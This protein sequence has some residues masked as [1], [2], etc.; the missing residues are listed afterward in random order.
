MIG[1]FGWAWIGI[2][3][4]LWACCRQASSWCR[5]PHFLESEFPKIVVCS[6]RQRLFLIKAGAKRSQQC[7]S[8]AQTPLFAP[9][10]NFSTCTRVCS[11]VQACESSRNRTFSAY[12]QF[13]LVNISEHWWFIQIQ[14]G[15]S[16]VSSMLLSRP[17]RIDMILNNSQ[18]FD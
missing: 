17:P 10:S 8:A 4:R 14:I 7:T 6:L 11:S 12:F 15:I 18:T 2:F 3:R 1:F 5:D 9:I 13:G 16:N